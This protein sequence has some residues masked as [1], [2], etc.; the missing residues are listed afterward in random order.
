MDV[1]LMCLATFVVGIVV[2]VI[3]MGMVIQGEDDE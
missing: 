2:G 3:I 1:G